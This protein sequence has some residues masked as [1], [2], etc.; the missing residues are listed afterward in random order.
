[1]GTGE[2]KM[3]LSE[4]TT[5]KAIIAALTEYD[6]LGDEIFLSQ[7][8]FG[9]AKN[10]FLV[11]DGK[12]YPSKA[13]VGV[14]RKYDCPEKGPMLS[15]EFVG[16]KPVQ[17]KLESLGFTV[18]VRG[19][20]EAGIRTSINK[21]NQKVKP[22]IQRWDKKGIAQ[23]AGRRL[24]DIDRF[25]QLLESL[26]NKTMGF[27]YLA[28][29]TG[30]MIWPRRG[31]YIFF[32]SGEVRTNSGVGYRVVRVGTHALNIGAKATLWDRLKAHKGIDNPPGGNHRGSVFRKHIGRAL[33]ER[34]YISEEL[35]R[36]WGVGNAAPKDVRENE[37]P[38]EIEVNH[39]IRKKPFLWLKVDD[40]PG[41][42][43]LRGYIERNAIGLLSNYQ[44]QS[45]IDPPSENWLGN[46]SDKIEIRESGL[47]NVM[48]VGEKYDP[49]FLEVLGQL[50]ENM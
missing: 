2:V 17:A 20:G 25:Y 12:K 15:S 49:Q 9:A 6:N 7:Y 23:P 36:T 26:Q 39:H 27:R 50:I 38:L 47:W 1:L 44:W 13:I 29:A 30:R 8:G 16:G 46:W 42:N 43:S 4:V 45:R 32:D 34:E 5:R 22:T 11:Y 18:K 28:T 3:P 31:V 35:S 41:P 24:A 37:R 40:P 21:T 10:Y 14:A 19:A 33:L 48:H